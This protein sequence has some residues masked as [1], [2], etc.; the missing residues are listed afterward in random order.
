MPGNK[1]TM[2]PDNVVQ[3]FGWSS[4]DAALTGTS[5]NERVLGHS[6]MT[7]RLDLELPF[8]L[9]L[10]SSYSYADEYP[11][12]HAN[13]W[14]HSYRYP[15]A[16]HHAYCHRHTYTNGYPHARSDINFNPHIYTFTDV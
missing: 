9:V 3:A 10:Q 7:G 16:N 2:L 11:Y 14:T 15:Y 4:L 12:Q 1:I 13:V 5:W 6:R 8:R